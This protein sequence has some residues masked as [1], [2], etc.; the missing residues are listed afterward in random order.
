MMPIRK[1]QTIVGKISSCRWRHLVTKYVTNASS[2]K[3]ATDKV[4]SNYGVNSWVRCA[5]GFTCI[6]SSYYHVTIILKSTDCC[7]SWIHLWVSRYAVLTAATCAPAL[8]NKA[9]RSCH[10]P[11]QRH[12]QAAGCIR[13]RNS[14]PPSATPRSS[15]LL[16]QGVDEGVR[17]LLFG[18]LP[19]AARG[20]LSVS[21]HSD[22]FFFFWGRDMRARPSP[23]SHGPI[24]ES[25]CWCWGRINGTPS[26][27]LALEHNFEVSRIVRSH[28][29]G[30]HMCTLIILIQCKCA[31]DDPP[32]PLLKT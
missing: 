18:F 9:E 32:H 11:Q 26:S 19:A 17:P 10:S 14:T 27:P 1:S 30:L 16:R 29:Y 3:F 22:L 8:G 20:T 28:T 5:S 25:R 12:T 2:A 23:R 7:N 6:W 4:N 15:S 13:W 21:V 24:S 31:I